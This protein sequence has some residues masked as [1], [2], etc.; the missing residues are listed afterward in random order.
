[1]PQISGS[2]SGKSRSQA[3]IVVDDAPG[4]EMSLVEVS[5]PQ[6]T[7]DPLWNGAT[8]RYWG[9]A[10][11]T[12]GNGTQTGY[13]TNR[14]ADGDTDRGTFSAKLSTDAGGA[15]TMEGMWA[16]T[17][18]TGKFSGISGNGTYKGAVTSP[19]EV[20]ISWEGSYRLA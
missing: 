17:G 8:V 5:G 18:G 7:S 3:L 4:H 12:A 9:I 20:E 11:L 1:M 13:F 14:H 19:T 6:A 10:D 2:F 16:F 15:T